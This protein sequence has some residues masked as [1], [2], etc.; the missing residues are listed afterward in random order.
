MGKSIKRPSASEVVVEPESGA[1]GS[2]DAAMGISNSNRA[3]Y[4]LNKLEQQGRPFPK[5]QYKQLKSWQAKRDFVNQLEIDPQCS[6]LQAE[7][8]QWATKAKTEV[9]VEGWMYLWDVA[10]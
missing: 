6:W 1:S 9:E 8:E 7:E 4:M 3:R 10:R 2:N 5:I